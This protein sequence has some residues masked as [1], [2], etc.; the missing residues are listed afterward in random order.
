M[1]LLRL[2]SLSLAA[3]VAVT[4]APLVAHA[5]G[6]TR[7]EEPTRQAPQR[8]QQRGPAQPREPGRTVFVSPDWLAQ[9]LNDQ[10]LRILDV[11]LN[12]R[13]YFIG[14]VPNAVHIADATFRGPQRG[15]PV[16]HLPRQD[17][18][19]LLQRSGVRNGDRVVI[20]S[21]G[22][23]VIGATMVGYILQTL[24]HPEVYILDGGFQGWSRTQPVTQ[25]YPEYR[26]GTF[27]IRRQ[28]DLSADLEDVRDVLQGRS[29]ATLVDARPAPL[30]RGET[31]IWQKNGHIPG[32]V[33]LD[34][35]ELVETSNPHQLK[36]LPELRRIIAERG[37]GPEDEI[38]LYCG[39][40]REA[41]L[42]FHVMRNMLGWDNVRLYE[43]SWTEYV[44]FDLPVTKGEER[45]ASR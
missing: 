2:Q 23:D 40:S 33:N 22:E 11:R 41:S 32:A 16:Q 30:Y 20:Y 10:D 18:G 13:D 25:R 37:L 8:A 45:A 17:M 39:T 1:K 14:H 12:P 27:T 44:A 29:R 42:V 5:Q 7:T 15:I 3:L 6:R 19:D 38:I 4:I 43:G 31:N 36:P 34:W 9:R 24:G 35:H 21:D 28:R 26:V